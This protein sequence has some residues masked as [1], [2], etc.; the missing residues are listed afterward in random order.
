MELVAA[1]DGTRVRVQRV[2]SGLVLPQI[3]GRDGWS[4]PPMIREVA[5]DSA[6]MIM[7]PPVLIQADPRCLLHVVAVSATA[8]D[9]SWLEVAELDQLT[10]PPTVVE[11]VRRSVAEYRGAAA[12]PDLRPDWFDP[13]WQSAAEHWVD[14]MLSDVGLQ[15]VGASEVIKFWSLSAIMRVAVRGPDG[16]AAVY[17]KGACPWFRA[18]PALT[19]LIAAASPGSVPSL[20]AVDTDRAWMLMRAFDQREDDRDAGAAMLAAREIARLQMMMTGRLD[21]LWAAGAPDR[22]RAATVDGLNLIINESVELDQ[23]SAR[24]R[25]T[26]QTMEPWLVGQLDA[27]EATGMPYSLGHG[28]L[29]LGNVTVVNDRALLYDWTDAAV[30]FPV[31]DIALLSQSAG[32]DDPA[33]VSAAYATLWREHCPAADIDTA[34]LLAPR[35]NRIYQAISYEGIY[36]AQEERTRWELGGIVAN[37][38]RALGQEWIAAGRPVAF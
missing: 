13:G 38:L 28:D 33:A 34:L 11:S 1:V 31:L 36:R 8:G 17:F 15:R 32:I 9:D 12:R 22:R 19:Q 27:L 3:T 10:H 25:Q 6:G 2:A 7:V 20:I 4:D 30:T 5:G 16:A 26:A 14:S 24:E 37:T 23:L 29:H 35:V 18:E 21:E